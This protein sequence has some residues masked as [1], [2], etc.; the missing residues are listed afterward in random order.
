MKHG[1]AENWSIRGSTHVDPRLE[2][3]R[4]ELRH[5]AQGRA[6]SFAAQPAKE[7]IILSTLKRVAPMINW[8]QTATPFGVDTTVLQHPGLAAESTANPGLCAAA[9]Q[10]SQDFKES[11][12]RKN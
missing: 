7:A 12:G 8:S 6:V 10:G 4:N 3:S 2:N 1:P 9:L 11:Q 5:K